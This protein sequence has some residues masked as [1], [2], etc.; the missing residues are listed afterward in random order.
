MLFCVCDVRLFA[1]PQRIV[2]IN[3]CTDELLPYLAQ[4]SRIKALTVYAEHSAIPKT[5]GDIEEVLSYSPDLVVGGAFSNSETIGMLR[6]LGIPVLILEV[7]QDFDGIYKNIRV[8]GEILHEGEKAR[9]LIDKLQKKLNRLRVALPDDAPVAVFYQRAGHVPGAKTF[10]HSVLEAAGLRNLGAELGIE[11][12][13]TLSL[14]ELIQAKPDILI[15]A[16]SGLEYNSIGHQLL[17]HPALYK[18]LPD[19]KIL[20]MPSQLLE[21]GSPKALDAIELIIKQLEGGIV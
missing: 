12:F 17:F 15:F 19:A 16:Q 11:G 10:Q 13:A 14:E 5:K 2:S 3:L 7:A 18:G 4:P 6:R 9:E 1:A 8:L 21:C 20:T